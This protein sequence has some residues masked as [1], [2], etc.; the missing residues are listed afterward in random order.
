MT[1]KRKGLVPLEFEAAQLMKSQPWSQ[2]PLPGECSIVV[3]DMLDMDDKGRYC[4]VG[5][6]MMSFD[7]LLGIDPKLTPALNDYAKKTL[8]FIDGK[9]DEDE[10]EIC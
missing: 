7:Y 4:T 5:G 9:I 8:Q 3:E 2:D 1:R 10:K 6:L